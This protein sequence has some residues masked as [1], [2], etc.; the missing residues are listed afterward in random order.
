[1]G[2]HSGC[3]LRALKAQYRALSRRG[4][5]LFKHLR[6]IALGTWW[7]EEDGRGARVDRR[8]M[9]QRLI[10][11]FKC[12]GLG[13]VAVAIKRKICGTPGWLSG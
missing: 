3:I 13:V 2:R 9:V 8:G 1:M 12:S 10:Q 7:R 5:D 11:S 6:E 4:H